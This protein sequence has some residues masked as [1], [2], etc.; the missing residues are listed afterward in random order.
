MNH[1]FRLLRGPYCQPLLSNSLSMTTVYS[2]FFP[3]GR[4]LDIFIRVP[5]P[6]AVIIYQ[7]YSARLKWT[8]LVF[9]VVVT[10]SHK[11]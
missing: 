8:L 7:Y 11:D 6:L 9:S 1:L 10:T 3:S 4:I 5:N 2:L